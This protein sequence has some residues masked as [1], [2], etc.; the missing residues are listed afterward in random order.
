MARLAFEKREPPHRDPVVGRP[1]R[2][3][4][5]ELDAHRAIN[6]DPSI[7]RQVFV[8]RRGE[9][10]STRPFSLAAVSH[11]GPPETVVEVQGKT[12]NVRCV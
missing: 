7:L 2:L 5:T 3:F 12:F 8:I 10:F 1:W 9:N 4:E 11:V 6:S